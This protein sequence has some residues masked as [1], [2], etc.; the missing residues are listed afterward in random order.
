V[1]QAVYHRDP[2]QNEAVYHRD[3]LQNEAVYYRDPLPSEAVSKR[4]IWDRRKLARKRLA[5]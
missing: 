5:A 2:L 3:P 4:T 1:K